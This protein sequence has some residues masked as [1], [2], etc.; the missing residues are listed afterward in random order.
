MTVIQ[1]VYILFN[2]NWFYLISNISTLTAIFCLFVCLEL[3]V[4]LENFLLIWRRHHCRWRAA[5]FD[6]CSAL[7]AIEQWGFFSVPHLLWH[8][9]SVYN[10]HFRATQCWAFSGGA[11]KTYFKVFRGW[12]SNTQPSACGANALTNCATAAAINC[13]EHVVH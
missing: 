11:V 2:T 8:G 12:D 13:Y 4:P 3:T 10:G 9:A 1:L 5:N 7:M 6:L